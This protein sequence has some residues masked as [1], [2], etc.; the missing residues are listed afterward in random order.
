MTINV[1][2]DREIKDMLTYGS[3]LGSVYV[4]GMTTIFEVILKSDV[5]NDYF[6]S[7]CYL[8]DD[9]LTVKLVSND[10]VRSI[11]EQYKEA[12]DNYENTIKID[13]SIITT[14]KFKRE[15][16]YGSFPEKREKEELFKQTAKET[17]L[18]HFNIEKQLNIELV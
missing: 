18:T 7:W 16:L 15:S 4:E 14:M 2:S 8:N 5:L 11:R 3:P 17:L 12:V 6:S 13:N 1:Y 10:K 9:I